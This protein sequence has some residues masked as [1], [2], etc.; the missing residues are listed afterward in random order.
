MRT[1]SSPPRV[2]ELIV[3]WGHGDPDAREALIPLLYDELRRIA[4]RHLHGERPDHT[5]QSAALVHEAY[6]RLIDLKSPPW[7]NRA[8]FFGAAARHAAHTSGPC[9]KPT[10]GKARRR[11]TAADPGRKERIASKARLGRGGSRRRAVQTRSPRS[12]TGPNYRDEVLQR[13]IH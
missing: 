5:L 9:A 2:S 11:S 3:N 1:E 13:A 6:V 12:T 4:R 8:H 10:G 7:Q